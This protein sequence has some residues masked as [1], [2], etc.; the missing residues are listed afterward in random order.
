MVEP[1]ELEAAL[2][3]ATGEP[4]ARPAFYQLLMAS[5][6]LVLADARAGKNGWPRSLIAWLRDDG[7]QVIPFF[8]SVSALP[9]A[10][11]PDLGVMMVP[12]RSL[13]KATRGTPLHLN[14]SS[15]FGREFTPDEVTSLLAWG[16]IHD[17]QNVTCIPADTVLQIDRL[18]TPLPALEGALRTLLQAH[19]GIRCSYLVEIERQQA[20]QLV[21][22][23]MMILE[24]TQT[25]DLVQSINIVFAGLY[26]GELPVDLHFADA[27]DELVTA[28]RSVGAV[29]LYYS[30]TT[31]H[32]AKS[33]HPSQ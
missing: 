6:V 19:P 23:V 18:A 33:L 9:P 11:E 5:K 2:E 24:G 4:A 16:T 21:R 17:G 8:S 25:P 22:T 3:R 26:G 30:A 27:A 7:I 10:R 31:I 1:T 20:S 12:V 29:P 32:L 14:P 13:L 28:L 15:T